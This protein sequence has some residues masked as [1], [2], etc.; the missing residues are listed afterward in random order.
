MGQETPFQF[1][2]APQQFYSTSYENEIA[3]VSPGSHQND[4]FSEYVDP[5]ELTEKEELETP[6]NGGLWF[7]ILL[8]VLWVAIKTFRKHAFKALPVIALLICFNNVSARDLVW[9]YSFYKRTIPDGKVA[10]WS[11]L[12]ANCC[13][14]KIY[15]S[16]SYYDVNFINYAHV[17]GEGLK[18]MPTANNTAGKGDIIHSKQFGSKIK[19]ITIRF[20][21]KGT[22]TDSLYRTAIFIREY[23]NSDYRNNNDSQRESYA[24]NTTYRKTVNDG[25]STWTVNI[26]AQW[27]GFMIHFTI[28]ENLLLKSIE[29]EYEDNPTIDYT[30]YK[31]YDGYNNLAY[32]F[33]DTAT[34][35]HSLIDTLAVSQ[36]FTEDWK[37]LGWNKSLF[38]DEANTPTSVTSVGGSATGDSIFHA[39]YSHSRPAIRP[40][41]S[42]TE[43][44]YYS[45]Y[46][47]VC[48]TINNSGYETDSDMIFPDGVKY[49][50]DIDASRFFY[51]SLP[52]DCP[53]SYIKFSN[54]N[55][56]KY[57]SGITEDGS[58]YVGDW[59]ITRWDESTYSWYDMKLSDISQEV[60]IAGY[61]YGI[62]I[63]P[64]VK[65]EV[66]FQSNYN[67]KV[68]PMHND[69]IPISFTP[70]TGEENGYHSG[71]NFMGTRQ[72]QPIDYTA[73]NTS[74]VLIA[75]TTDLDWTLFS[76]FGENQNSSFTI[77][78]FSTF[79]VQTNRDLTYTVNPS[80]YVAAT[81]LI[82]HF[83]LV[84]RQEDNPERMD[85]TTIV[86][87]SEY[88]DDYEIGMDLSKMLGQGNTPQIFSVMDS[89]Y[90]AV[91]ASSYNVGS[92][93]KV[94]I[95]IPH[96]EDWT[97]SLG[98][99]INIPSDW[100]IIL[101]DK[102]T[103]LVKD[104][105]VEDMQFNLRKGFYPNRFELE[106]SDKTVDVEYVENDMTDPEWMKVITMS[107]IVVYDGKYDRAVIDQLMSGI[108]V[109][110]T[111]KWTKKCNVSK[112]I[113]K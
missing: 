19:S 70:P 67:Q 55:I 8:A 41:A 74:Y 63:V 36:L 72:W 84:I 50:M 95:Y 48:P 15:F 71:W 31:F 94:G 52:F 34:K 33:A 60:L 40:D 62:G 38:H 58:E 22:K 86:A 113:N 24:N 66:C 32:A 11:F 30:N 5:K 92:K 21:F 68:S 12:G 26:N 51:F 105:T 91:N 106:I 97:I 108:Y 65:T 107:G 61:G 49:K 39:F 2:A 45:L 96:K 4:N 6:I 77:K 75:N 90:H 78:P 25:D 28:N 64:N 87:S 88:T 79:M 93:I 59:L 46:S 99:N 83:N 17:S 80:Q 112:G 111:D 47:D 23:I 81:D 109:V 43:L 100:H 13:N 42:T 7:L 103:G 85:Y 9:K 18:L 57:V 76:Q 69:T 10:R 37:Y 101:K 44:R 82:D 54:P 89:T 1:E 3:Y 14:K 16:N 98:R 56:A 110:H 53:L 104:L 29:I 102:S 27:Q 35:V 73:I 20:D